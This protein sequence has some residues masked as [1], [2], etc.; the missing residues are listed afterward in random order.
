MSAR[1]GMDGEKDGLPV[2]KRPSRLVCFD[3]VGSYRYFVTLCTV[4]KRQVF[5][6]GFDYASFVQILSSLAG[7]FGIDVLVYCFMPDH[8]HL[9]LEGTENTNLKEFIRVFKQMTSYNFKDDLG[10]LWQ[11]SYYDRV[12]R[13]DEDSVAVAR[14]ILN[15][16]VRRGLVETVTDYQYSGSFVAPLEDIL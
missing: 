1:P 14:Y 11:R 13:R 16:P 5:V 3:Y 7:R 6:P 4:G 15:N 10:S 12:L 9:L 8:V 2:R